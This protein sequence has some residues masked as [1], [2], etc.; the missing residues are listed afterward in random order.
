MKEKHG[1]VGWDWV[2]ASYPAQRLLFRSARKKID[3]PPPKKKKKKKVSSKK[4]RIRRNGAES[5]RSW[6]HFFANFY[7]DRQV[8]LIVGLMDHIG[9]KINKKYFCTGRMY[10]EICTT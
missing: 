7:F 6:N 2:V 1:L 5:A 3:P 9:G 8:S 4:K 10:E